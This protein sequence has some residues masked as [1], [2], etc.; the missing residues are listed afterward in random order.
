MVIGRLSCREVV[1]MVIKVGIEKQ[2]QKTCLGTPRSEGRLVL[3]IQ[4]FSRT[5]PAFRRKEEESQAEEKIPLVHVGD[6]L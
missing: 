2:I 3:V 4:F 6:I 1:S 5:Q